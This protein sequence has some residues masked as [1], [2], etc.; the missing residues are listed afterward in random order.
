MKGVNSL[1]Q[2]IREENSLAALP[3]ITVSN[4][5][6]LDER[7][8]REQCSRRMLEIVVDIDRYVGTGRLFIP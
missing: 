3:V 2:T 7:V 5:D 4:V 8:Y 1:E 6:R